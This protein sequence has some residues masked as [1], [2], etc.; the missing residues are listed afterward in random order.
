MA[1]LD[2]RI[3]IDGID[4][5]QISLYELRRH[6]SIIP[7]VDHEKKKKRIL[8]FLV[9]SGSKDP[10]LF[11]DTLRINLDP[12]GEYSDIEIWRALDEV[13]NIRD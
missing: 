11:N 12:F 4:T 7:Q 13:M 10:V 2:G 8:E 6:I 9:F 3:L 1:E 5:K